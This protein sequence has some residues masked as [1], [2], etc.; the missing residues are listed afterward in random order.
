MPKKKLGPMNVYPLL[1]KTNCERCAQKVCMSFAVQLC[2]R[3][4]NLEECPPLFEE[5]TYKENLA[6]LRELLASAVK[7]V[8]IGVGDHQVKIGGELVLRRHELRYLNPTAIAVVVDDEMPEDKILEQVKQTK[9][10]RHKY[11][12]MIL[13][14]DMI[15][16]RSTS[17]DPAKFENAVK[18]VAETTDMPLVLWSLDPIVLERGLKI[19]EERRPLIYAAT[20]ENWSGM[21][22]LALKYKCPLAVYSPND[23]KTLRSIVSALKSWGVEDLALDTGAEFGDGVSNTVNNFTASRISA[24]TEEDEFLSFPLIGAPVR[25]W[26]K[27]GNSKSPEVVQWEEACLASIMIVRYADLIMLKT[28]NMWST[29]PLAVLRNNIYNDPRK[30]VNVD[31]GLITFGNP[32]AENSPVFLTSN[33]A[34]TY[35]TVLSDIEK[36]DGYLLVA[37]TEGLSVEAAV[38]GR[39]L[40]AETV[41]N[42]IQSSKI[43]DKIKHKTLI[44]PGFAARLKGDIEDATKWDVLVGPK[45]SSM[46]AG[47]LSEK[48]EGKDHTPG[49]SY[50]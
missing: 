2:E 13:T 47:F 50:K 49:W 6:K 31:P 41:V 15:A 21:G 34:L 30:P 12:G 33:F 29:L 27:D 39:K 28:A 14:L 7:E 43:E 26:D 11:I 20:R 5:E 40:T 37:D 22:E 45:D 46:I 32:N 4:V 8:A 44:I 24:I 48:W 38:A 1:P 17:N 19:V 36:M 42:I 10:F 16:V 23:V 35:Y 25:V 9:E 3:N 18:K